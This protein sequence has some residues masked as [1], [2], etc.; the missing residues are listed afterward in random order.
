MPSAKRI[1]NFTGPEIGQAIRAYY[2][3][4]ADSAVN[5]RADQKENKLLVSAEAIID[6][7][8]NGNQQSQQ[9]TSNV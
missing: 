9:G 2:G 5:I 1:V 6:E 3:L 7:V 8:E 4:P